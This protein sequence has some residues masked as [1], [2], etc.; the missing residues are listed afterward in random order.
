M[1]DHG[2]VMEL[3]NGVYTIT[4]KGEKY[5]SGELNA[6]TLEEQSE[7]GDQSAQA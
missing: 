5:L 2:L 3:G 4:S 6:E 7:N 1:K